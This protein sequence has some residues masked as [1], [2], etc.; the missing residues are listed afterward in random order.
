[1][2]TMNKV[3]AKNEELETLNTKQAQEAVELQQT[4]L[5]LKFKIQQL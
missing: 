4:I 3:E 5:D 2:M 1:M